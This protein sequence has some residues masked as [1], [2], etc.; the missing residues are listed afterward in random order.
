MWRGTCFALSPS[1]E[2]AAVAS[3]C[4]AAAEGSFHQQR[5]HLWG[6]APASV[7][8][9]ASLLNPST[10][11]SDSSRRPP[12]IT[13]ASAPLRVFQCICAWPHRH[14]VSRTALSC[15]HA[16]RRFYATTTTADG[17][18]A[19]P[20][21]TSA[22]EFEKVFFDYPVAER[23]AALIVAKHEV[24]HGTG[25]TAATGTSTTSASWLYMPMKDF[26]KR[27]SPLT[28]DDM[29]RRHLDVLEWITESKLLQLVNESGETIELES[30]RAHPTV[31][32]PATQSD[33]AHPPLYNG[34]VHV[35]TTIPA[36]W[37]LQ[38]GGGADRV[39]EM[40]RPCSQLTHWTPPDSVLAGAASTVTEPP[41]TLDESDDGK[42]GAAALSTAEREEIIKEAFLRSLRNW[43]TSMQQHREGAVTRAPSATS[44]CTPNLPRYTYLTTVYKAILREAAGTTS[45]RGEDTEVEVASDPLTPTARYILKRLRMSN[46]ESIVDNIGVVVTVGN[47]A[48][49]RAQ[50]PDG[51]PA[52]SSRPIWVV[53]GTSRNPVT[54]VALRYSTDTSPPRFRY[55]QPCTIAATRANNFGGWGSES[56]VPTKADVYEI[57]KY[58]PVNWGS[59]GNLNLPP[60]VKRRHIRA[61]STLMWF[62]RQPFY[63]E[64]RDMNGT[65]ELR[66][67]IVLHPEAHGMTKEEA[68][69]VLELQLA[70]GEANSLVPLGA[71][72]A[73][74]RPAERAFD[75]SI[76]KFVYRVCPTYFAPL[77]LTM[78]R[79]GKKN[80]TEPMLMAFVRR[81]PQ[82]FEVLTSR[83]SDT[84]LVRRRAGADSARW[85]SDFVAD[86]ERYPEDVR[87]ILI[88]CNVMCVAW[89]RPEYV[90]VRLSQTEQEVLGGYSG[91]QTIL[92][93]HPAIFRVGRHFVCRTDPSNPLAQRE[94]EPAVDDVTSLSPLHQE[95]PYHS[96][97]ELALV[98]HYVMPEDEP[99][100]AAYLV[101]CSSPAMRAVLPPRLVTIVQLFPKMFACTETSPGVYCIRKL[102]QPVRRAA[103]GTASVARSPH[104]T[105][106]KAPAVEG[107]RGSMDNDAIQMLEDELADEDHMTREEV[108]QTVRM[109]IPESG[110]EA[111]QLLLWASMSVQRAASEYYG[112]V[113]RLVEAHPG[114]FRVVTNEHT[115]RIYKK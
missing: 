7:K 39:S 59:I 104:S 115:K 51:Y 81:F 5:R 83:Y 66:R 65:V 70:T 36:A 101:D 35:R 33:A 87:A 23:L 45:A 86:L 61:S 17:D 68:W 24:G 76:T 14:G 106:D 88:L 40:K 102:K 13:S 114:Q 82:D 94:A 109:L 50:A 37:L 52:I 63:F 22:E 77:S 57:L 99:C 10:Y 105:G 31:A 12:R 95:N 26:V 46:L 41:C 96:P 62:R 6:D 27:M 75:R 34:F 21:A 79:Y 43:D 84:P 30:L 107:S 100:T 58:V 25:S 38:A 78:Q 29:L 54:F 53:R 91:M 89:D 80:L 3:S 111:P 47:T 9:A 11:K 67:S 97:K 69:E 108:V 16:Q 92:S 18:S 103:H 28:R 1:R 49:A 55:V 72:G 60:E 20:L 113:L 42:D 90:Y 74:L 71:D 19:S 110:V 73:P 48:S 8:T 85:M 2:A 93:R 44:G 56:V 32:G 64:V 15:V 112:G 4:C 98:F